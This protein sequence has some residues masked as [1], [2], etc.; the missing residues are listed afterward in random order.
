MILLQKILV[1][2]GIVEQ[3]SDLLS[4]SVS[5]QRRRGKWRRILEKIVDTFV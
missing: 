1:S 5:H 3:N 4:L 2:L